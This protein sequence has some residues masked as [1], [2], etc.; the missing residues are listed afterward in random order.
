MQSV[1]VVDGVVDAQYVRHAVARD[2]HAVRRASQR[3]LQVIPIRDATQFCLCCP[4]SLCANTLSSHSP[5]GDGSTRVR[6]SL[7]VFALHRRRN[8]CTIATLFLSSDHQ[9][10]D[11]KLQPI[12]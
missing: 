9:L 8:V 6:N 5:N 12:C 4:L 10:L 2:H 3:V 11:W 7:L 1:T